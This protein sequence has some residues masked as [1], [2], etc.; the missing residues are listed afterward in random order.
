M[1]PCSGASSRRHM[2]ALFVAA[3]V[4][5]LALDSPAYAYLDPG[6][7]SIILQVVL[8]GTAGVM[9]IAKLYWSQVKSFFMRRSEK[10]LVPENGGGNRDKPVS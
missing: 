1:T 3:F 2:L 7:G 9:V 8:G 6:T 5:M 10:K 4:T